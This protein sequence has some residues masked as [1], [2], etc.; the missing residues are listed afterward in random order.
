[1]AYTFSKSEADFGLNDSSGGTSPFAVLDRNNRDLDYGESDINRPHIF[2]A[3]FILNLPTFSDSN[4]FVRTVI[5]GWEAAS[6][7]QLSSGNTITPQINATGIRGAGLGQAFQAGITG[8]GTNVGNQRPLRVE[9]VPCTIDDGRTRFIN[10][11]AFTLVGY[12]IGQTTP[13]KAACLGAPTRNVDFSLLKNFTPSWLKGSFLG[14]QARVQFRL[15]FFNAFN[16]PNFLF[17]GNGPLPFYNGDIVCGNA[18]CSVTNNTITGYANGINGGVT[19][20]VGG[21]FGIAPATRGAREIQYA[22]K[23]YF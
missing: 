14:E 2:V 13:K 11:A 16:T 1:L 5:G 21:N 20:N 19:T 22:L 15:E 17:T 18:P 4:G 23:L 6:I 10:P 8:T 3:N 9:G 12:K 7:I